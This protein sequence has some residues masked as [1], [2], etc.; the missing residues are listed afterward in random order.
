MH[1]IT[2]RQFGKSAA[3]AW[4]S[5]AA[6]AARVLGANDRVRLGFIGLGNR[7]DQVLDAFLD[8][9]GRARSS[10]SATS[11]SRTST[12]PRRR[13]AATPKQFTDYRKLLDSKD[14]DAVVIARRTT[15]T[16]CR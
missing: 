5:T 15:G 1:T 8:A 16:R 12:S 14:L 11:T 10:P 3:A 13:P 2:R 9:Q 6:G 4:L 7:G